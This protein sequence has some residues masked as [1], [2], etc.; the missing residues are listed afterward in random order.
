MSQKLGRAKRQQQARTAKCGQT[1]TIRDLPGQM[2]EAR[3]SGM[4]YTEARQYGA[5]VT[6]TKPANVNVPCNGCTACCYNPRIEVDR[7]KEPPERLEHLDLVPDEYG[8]LKLRKRPDGACVHLGEK[9]CTVYEH[10]PTVCRTYD[11]RLLA[12]VGLRR[13]YDAHGDTVVSEP[14]WVF[15]QETRNDRILH[16]A[17]G[18]MGDQLRQMEMPENPADLDRM[19]AVMIP[20]FIAKTREVFDQCDERLARMTPKERAQWEA[21][22]QAGYRRICTGSVSRPG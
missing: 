8:D 16:E 20:A 18:L 3:H 9:G 7:S 5:R 2:V 21:K 17:I 10:R 13:A 22:S 15:D 19:L 1:V 4:T 12:M 14:A 6:Q 11:C